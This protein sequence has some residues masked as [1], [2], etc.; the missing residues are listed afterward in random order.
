MFGVK[1]PALRKKLLQERQ[2]TL[3]KAIDICKSG[4]IT[5]QHMKDLATAT[6]ANEIHALKH[7]KEKK[8]RLPKD[9][10]DSKGAKTCN[11]CGGN[12]EL[13]REK[14]P[15]YGKTC[16]KCGKSNHFAKVCKKRGRR[17]KPVNAVSVSSSDTGESLFTIQLTP[18]VDSVHAIQ[19]NIPSKIAAAMKLKGGPEINFQIDTGAT[20]DVLKL[21]SIKGTK[22]A[23]RITPTNQV[24]KM[25]NASTLRPLGKCKVQ[26]TNSRDKRQYTQSDRE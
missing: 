25:Y 7:H 16:G 20:C 4:E 12:H 15:A 8:P 6:D 5:A 19:S 26:L 3:E 14:C 23:N 11:Y 17:K 18:E 9:P 2:L 24:L 21:S 10:R 13:K 22:Y 1:E